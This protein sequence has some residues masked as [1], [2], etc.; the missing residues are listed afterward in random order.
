MR[1]DP[2]AFGIATGSVLG[3]AGFVATLFSLWRGAGYTITALAGIYIGYSWSFVGAIVALAWGL[4][5]GFV[6]GWIFATVYNRL[7]RGSASS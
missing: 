6:G 3:L 7:A 2:K 5:Y 1:L 4:F